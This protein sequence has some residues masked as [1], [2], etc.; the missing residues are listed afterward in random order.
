MSLPRLGALD[1]GRAALATVPR[2]ELWLVL[3]AMILGTALVLVY[4]LATRPN[5]LTGDQLVYHEQ[6]V[7]FTEGKLWWTSSP[8]GIPHASPW[9][10]PLYGAWVG[11]LY[12][13]LGVSTTR[14]LIVQSLLAAVT[15][16]LAW[17]LARRLFGPRAAVA[18]A[19]LVAAFP[20]VW[21][22]FGLLYTE[23][24]AIPL[25][26]LMFLLFLG[27]QPTTRLAVTLGVVMG[28]SLLLRPSS[29]FVIAAVAVAWALAVGLRRGMAL[30]AICVG[31]AALVVLP[32]T[33]RNYVVADGFVPISLQ[34]TAVYGTFNDVS[35]SDPIYP[36][37]WR[38]IIPEAE[39]ILGGPPLEDSEL[40]SELISIATDHIAEHPTSIV[41]A[42]FWNGLSR[43]WDIRRP[44]RAMDEVPFEG[45]SEAVTA[46][47]LVVY[48]V[49]LPFAIFGLWRHRARR[50]LILPII[51][52]AL[53]ASIVFTTASGTRYRAP[54]EPLIAILAV[55]A[56][57]RPAHQPSSDD[58]IRLHP[59]PTP[60]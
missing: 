12:E 38:P 51:A 6:A 8:F 43:Y 25:V 40:R 44:G 27:K 60:A 58:T 11:G 7:F 39:A 16:G 49:L 50:E 14:V 26:L 9:K 56:F 23:A 15:V 53:A 3:T 47:G 22:W 46:T 55:A 2:S 59:E 36:Y 21:E 1:K 32:W 45:R 28:V 33:V 35:A 48:Y 31:V 52:L 18:S 54:L 20:L 29:F 42:F 17:G 24:L 57:V 30:T 4:V 10:A 13:L 37:A 19:F 5:D 34:D 41:E